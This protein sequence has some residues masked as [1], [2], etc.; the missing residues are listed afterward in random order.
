MQLERVRPTVLR[1][2]LHAY[3]LAALIAA[4]GSERFRAGAS[5]S[6]PSFLRLFTGVRGIGILRSSPQASEDGIILV[7]ERDDPPLGKGVGKEEYILCRKR[8]RP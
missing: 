4:A 1:L 8:T 2:T 6:R 3:E 5:E 7:V